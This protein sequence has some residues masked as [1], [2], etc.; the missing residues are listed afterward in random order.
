MIYSDAPFHTVVAVV[1][2]PSSFQAH[3]DA[4]TKSLDQTEPVHDILFRAIDGSL[5]RWMKLRSSGSAGG[6][7]MDAAMVKHLC[8]SFKGSF[9][10]L[11]DAFASFARRLASK[12][13]DPIIVVAFFACHLISLNKNPG[14]QLICVCKIICRV[15][16]KTSLSVIGSD[17][18]SVTG[19]IQL[20][21]GQLGGCEAAVHAMQK[22][23]DNDNVDSI[24]WLTLQTLS[25]A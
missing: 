21:S 1:K 19:V 12:C 13:V 17:I 11:F 20:C 10:V 22:I 14:I 5:I 23:Y 8:N 7:G 9:N 15:I 3:C 4:M 16:G 2:Y 24:L 25:T 18:Q 6:S